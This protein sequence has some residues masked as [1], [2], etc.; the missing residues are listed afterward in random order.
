MRCVRATEDLGMKQA[1]LT[2]T[3]LITAAVLAAR[4][5]AAEPIRL[6]LGG[7]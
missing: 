7:L 2:T 5:E 3:A 4:A 1:L 6:T